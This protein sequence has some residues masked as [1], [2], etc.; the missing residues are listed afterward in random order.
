MTSVAVS[1]GKPLVCEDRTKHCRSVDDV[2]SILPVSADKQ[3]VLQRTLATEQGTVLVP[4]DDATQVKLAEA[5]HSSMPV[6]SSSN[7]GFNREGSLYPLLSPSSSI[8][9]A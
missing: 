9:S 6:T 5:R 4:A 2:N 3:K 8:H 1:G 7:G